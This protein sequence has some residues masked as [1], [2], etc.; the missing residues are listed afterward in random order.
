V[1]PSPTR[2]D[3]L[4]ATYRLQLNAGFDFDAAADVAHYLRD[5]GISHVYASP[6]LAARR[7]STHGYDVVDFARINPELGGEAGFERLHDAL[8]RNGLGLIL[9][10]VPNHMGVGAENAWWMDVLARGR[11]SPFARFFAIDW[12]PPGAAWRDK[13]L[14]PVLGAPY[15]EVF[16]NGDIALRFDG[17]TGEIYV[18]YYENRFPVAPADYGTVLA[19]ADTS[20]RA[21]VERALGRFA[22]RRDDPQ[23]CDRLHALLERQHY[24]LAYWRTGT[25]Q[26][27]YRRFFEINDLAALRQ[28]DPAVFAATHA[29]LLELIGAGKVDGVRLDHVDGLRDPGA[30]LRRLKRAIDRARP[31]QKGEPPFPLFVEKILGSEEALPDD[32]PVAGTT[33]YEAMA[34]LTG[35]QVDPAAEDAFTDLWARC[36]GDRTPFEATV[37]AC[38][39]QVIDASFT[40]ETDRLTHAALRLAQADGRTCGLTHDTLRTA[41]V[42][43]LAHFP[44]YRTYVD[45]RGASPDDRRI[46]DQA[47]ATTAE[48]GRADAAA[49]RFLQEVL[50]MAAPA[51]VTDRATRTLLAQ[52]VAQFQQLSGPVTAKSV[53]DT[54]FYRYSR[55]VCLNEVGAEPGRFGIAPADFHADMAARAK[56]W[57]QAMLSTATHDHKRGEDVRARLAVLSEMPTEW[58][59][60]V[61]RWMP[62]LRPAGADRAPAPEDACLFLQT[63]VGAWPTTLLPDDHAGL[64]AFAERLA[65]YMV[66][67]ARE[68]KAHTDWIAPDADYEAALQRAAR[69]LLEPGSL[70][71]DLHAF[72]QRI[73]GPGALNGL[74]QVAL[75]ACAPGVPDTYQGCAFW[76]QSLVDPDNRQPVDFA[77]RRAALTDAARAD[78]SALLASWQDGRIKQFVLA[79]LLG[80]RAR[81]PELWSR[82]TYEPVDIS[83]DFA[84]RLAAFQRRRR[85]ASALVVVPR[86]AA[87][88]L[89]DNPVPHVAPAKWKETHVALAADGAVGGTLINAFTGHRHPVSNDRLS[90]AELLAEFPIA[91]LTTPP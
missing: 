18:A 55:L 28:E 44:V 84:G 59:A 39:R 70:A 12:T 46:L 31:R 66:K 35:L 8:R 3:P 9:D 1:T 23:A 72:Q 64:S 75:K 30:Y 14:L 27:N 49:L 90:V 42:E 89:Q 5:L 26:I 60:A 79:R 61:E 69:R 83:G 22:A 6:I 53:E 2:R 85:H 17:E 57:P 74:A 82:G 11:A 36:S 54:A 32:W 47:V 80:L 86:L 63:A 38:K 67:A 33:G 10:F 50:G 20:H 24:R 37:V 73:A 65:A 76:D 58:A 34:L 52:V 15:A 29:L 88:L 48:A 4:R 62:R 91:V 68:A 51:G 40:A 87:S 7:G 16:A 21:S 45:R 43:L 19:D 78:P 56:R 25:R 77:T 81:D 41:I 13:V 71:T